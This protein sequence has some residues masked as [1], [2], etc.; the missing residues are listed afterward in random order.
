MFFGI[1]AE[2]S[3]I[4]G[5]G[6]VKA[7]GGIDDFTLGPLSIRGAKGPRVMVDYELISSKQAGKIDGLIEFLGVE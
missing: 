4:I 6:G 7:S 3:V 1:K 2:V 5:D